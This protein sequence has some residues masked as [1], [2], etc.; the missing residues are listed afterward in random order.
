[1]ESELQETMHEFTDHETEDQSQST[2]YAH[3][4]HSI[5]GSVLSIYH[6]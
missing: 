4:Q 3:A 1:M 5:V 2:V 6:Y